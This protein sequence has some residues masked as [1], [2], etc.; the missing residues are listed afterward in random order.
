MFLQPSMRQVHG[1]LVA[2]TQDMLFLS[3]LHGYCFPRGYETRTKI[4]IVSTEIYGSSRREETYI[5]HRKRAIQHF[6]VKTYRR[7]LKRKE[8]VR[9]SCLKV[10][11]DRH[12]YTFAC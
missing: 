12:E 3:C 8:N 6:S 5:L 10:A 2:L 4:C 9:L 7:Q 11:L 1:T